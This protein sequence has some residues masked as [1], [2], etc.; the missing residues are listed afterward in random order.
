MKKKTQKKKKIYLLFINII[1]HN[2]NDNKTLYIYIYIM[3]NIK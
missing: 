2:I 3:Q 1:K